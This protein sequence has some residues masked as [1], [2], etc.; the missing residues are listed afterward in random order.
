MP[1]AERIAMAETMLSRQYHTPNMEQLAG[2]L[3]SYLKETN[4][5]MPV[6]KTS[7]KPV[8]YPIDTLRTRP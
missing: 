5:L 3:S 2:L 1:G 6:D 7:G 4:A 8:E